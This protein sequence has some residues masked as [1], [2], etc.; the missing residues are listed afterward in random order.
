[1]WEPSPARRLSVARVGRR[2]LRKIELARDE[3]R[4]GAIGWKL[5]QSLAKKLREAQQE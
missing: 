5:L 3:Q 1:M 2:S 4:N